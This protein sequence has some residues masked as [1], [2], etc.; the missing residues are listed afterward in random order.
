M[1]WLIVDLANRHSETLVLMETL[2]EKQVVRMADQKLLAEVVHAMLNGVSTTSALVLDKMYR[3]YERTPIPDESFL[4]DSLDAAFNHI[5]EWDALHETGLPGKSYMFYALI[6]ALV[7]VESQCHTLKK[8]I[9]EALG[10]P[11]HANAERNLIELS[12]A[13]ENE[14]DYFAEFVKASSEKTNTREQRETR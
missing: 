4:R 13:V 9:A 1:K 3:Q 7:A 2:T 14:S 11:I 6:L 10:K 8:P 5:L 12:D